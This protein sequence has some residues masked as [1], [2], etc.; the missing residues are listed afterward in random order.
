MHV[1]VVEDDAALN[2]ILARLL[3]EEGHS[4]DC[5][6]DGRDGLDYQRSP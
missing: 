4:V 1:L 2:G 3:S 5:C 6:L